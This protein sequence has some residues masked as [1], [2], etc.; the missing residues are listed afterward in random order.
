MSECL[1][2]VSAVIEILQGAT[3]QVQR[4]PDEEVQVPESDA[5]PIARVATVPELGAFRSTIEH[6]A[7]VHQIILQLSALCLSEEEDVVEMEID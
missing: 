6:E 2:I 1:E 4:N 7:A 3:T 5:R